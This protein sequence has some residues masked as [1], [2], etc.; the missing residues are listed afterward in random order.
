M[1]KGNTEISDG[2]VANNGALN[3]DGD[4]SGANGGSRRERDFFGRKRK[5]AVRKKLSD[6]VDAQ[7]GALVMQGVN[8]A[9]AERVKRHKLNWKEHKLFMWV[10]GVVLVTSVGLLVAIVAVN[11]AKNY[12]ET[13]NEDGAQYIAEEEVKAKATDCMKDGDIGQ[14]ENCLAAL[15]D[16]E[17]Y[18]LTDGDG[19][20]N[21]VYDTVINYVLDGGELSTE[22]ADVDNEDRTVTA[23]YL[24]VDKAYAWVFDGQC[25]KARVAINDEN[26]TSRMSATARAVLYSRASGV[27]NACDYV[28]EGELWNNKMMQAMQE[29]SDE[30]N[31]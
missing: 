11:V 10:S 2:V 16:S 29:V 15:Y 4:V 31:A 27:A 13:H 14:I 6:A 1:V 28:E 25:C 3:T 12:E 18:E 5:D 9:R 30:L 8:L 7:E 22:L 23:A 17:N 26:I 20:I 24:L 21:T 19:I